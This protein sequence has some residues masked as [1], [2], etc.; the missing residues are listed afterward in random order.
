MKELIRLGRTDKT[1]GGGELTMLFCNGQCYDVEQ[2]FTHHY[3]P[4][5]LIA[6]V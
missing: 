3:K 1:H 6:S 2:S 4:E 5:T